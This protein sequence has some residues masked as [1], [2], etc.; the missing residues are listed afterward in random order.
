M[1][2]GEKDGDDYFK[3]PDTPLTLSS[4]AQE[5]KKGIALEDSYAQ[6]YIPLYAVYD[7]KHKEYAY[8]FDSRYVNIKTD[9]NSGKRIAML[10]LFEIKY[11]DGTQENNKVA[12][13]NFDTRQ[14]EEATPT[15]S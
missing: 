12:R 3:Y 4:N 15:C 6:M 5:L 14:F 1:K 9:K 13:I 8:V 11:S 10:N 7:F 2:W